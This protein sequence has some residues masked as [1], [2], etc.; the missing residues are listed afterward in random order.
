MA[1]RRSEKRGQST[2]E[3]AT[4]IAAVGI[5]LAAMTVYVQR[6]MQANLSNVEDELNAAAA[7]V[8]GIVAPPP[9][10]DQGGPDFPEPGHPRPHP[11]FRGNFGPVRAEE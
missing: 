3:Y 8:P 1:M 4:L 5:A 10:G 7:E 9:G 11:R 6:A 2:L